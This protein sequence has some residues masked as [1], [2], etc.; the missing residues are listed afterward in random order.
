MENTKK[1]QTRKKAGKPTSLDV[2]IAW[3][4]G[5]IANRCLNAI[6]HYTFEVPTLFGTKLSRRNLGNGNRRLVG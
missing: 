5:S 2:T 4:A 3:R 6:S 1:L